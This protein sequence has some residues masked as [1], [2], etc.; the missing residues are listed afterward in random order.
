[1]VEHKYILYIKVKYFIIAFNYWKYLDCSLSYSEKHKN[2]KRFVKE[3]LS[4]CWIFVVFVNKMSEKEFRL[5]NQIDSFSQ[6][7]EEVK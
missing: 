6:N 3:R 4:F 7:E 1:M 2:C 5:R